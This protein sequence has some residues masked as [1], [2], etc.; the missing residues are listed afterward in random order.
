MAQKQRQAVIALAG[1]CRQLDDAAL[2]DSLLEQALKD[3]PAAEKLS[4]TLSVVE[5]YWQAGQHKKAEALLDGLLADKEL[6]QNASLW[7]LAARLANRERMTARGVALLDKALEVEFKQLPP[8]INLQ[9]VRS[10][11]GQLLNAYQQLINATAMLERTAPKELVGK[12][13]RAADRW[14]ALDPD[15]TMAC[16]AAARALKMLGQNDLAWEYLTTPAALRPNEA[17]P[18]LQ[19]AQALRY[20][21]DG[22]LADQAY[23]MAFEREPTNAQIL[24]ERAQ[25]L[26]QAGKLVDARKVYRQISDGEWQ[27]RFRW[28]QQQ[29]RWQ[30][31][32]R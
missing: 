24:M 17:A 2:A 31:G 22:D 25:A 20:D 29:A 32:I 9:Q 26:Q 7:H 15:G 23:A 3:V 1:Q 4:V 19:L 21:G 28:V 30:L 6:S 10:E 5:H 12:V 18:F 16:Q 11:Y 13:V 27:P 8:V 14:R